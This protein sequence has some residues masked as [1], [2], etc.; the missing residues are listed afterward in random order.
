MIPFFSPKKPCGLPFKEAFQRCP[1]LRK[2]ANKGNNGIDLGNSQALLLYNRLVLQ[3]FMGL[4]FTVP[5]GYLIPT[6]CSRWAFVSWIIR[7]RSP[8]NVLEIGTGA[9]AILA[10]MFARIGCHVEA[11]EIDEI[12]YQSAQNNIKK[13]GLTSQIQL[14]KVQD[15][16]QILMNCYDSL[17]KFNALVCNPPQYDQNFFYQQSL[18]KG[19]VG[20]ESELVG[21]EKGHEFIIKLIEEVKRYSK[22]PSVYF[23]L[24]VPKLHQKICSYLQNNGFSFLEDHRT[25]GTRQRFY[26]RVD[27]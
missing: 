10:M 18:S 23:Q 6:V 13:N 26:F 3:D 9:S 16:N 14:R 24:T 2:H 17:T 7:E 8:L 4:D 12:A 5:P 25:I 1:A 11:T 27:Y 19:F 21:G 15:E 20:Q 22:P